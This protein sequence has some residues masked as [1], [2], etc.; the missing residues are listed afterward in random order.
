[1]EQ[2]FTSLEPGARQPRLAMEPDGLANTKTRERAEGAAP[3]VQAKHGDSCTA[4]KVQ[5]GPKTSTCFGVMAEPPDLPSRGDVLV[6]NG[7][8][9]FSIIGDA[10]TNSRWWFTSQR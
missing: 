8:G 10:L 9:L 4:Q 3:A 6:K 5:D 1:M 7:A 2:H